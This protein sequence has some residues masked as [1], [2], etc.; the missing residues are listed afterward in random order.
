M[1]LPLDDRFAERFNP[2]WPAA[3][4]L[5]HGKSQLLFGGMGRLRRTTVINIKN[6]SY[7]R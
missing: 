4:Q 5:I 7:S 1:F 3:R 2:K 6:K